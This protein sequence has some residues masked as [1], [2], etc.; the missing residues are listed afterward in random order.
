[1]INGLTSAYENKIAEVTKLM[2][3]FEEDDALVWWLDSKVP[4]EKKAGWIEFWA[5]PVK[6]VNWSRVLDKDKVKHDIE[7][8]FEFYKDIEDLAQEISEVATEKGIGAAESEINYLSEK[9]K[10]AVRDSEEEKDMTN[11]SA[12]YHLHRRLISVQSRMISKLESV[13][14]KASREKNRELEGK[15]ADSV[16]LNAECRRLYDG[17]ERHNR[18]LAEDNHE[19]AK[20][21][22]TVEEQVATLM[23]NMTI[24]SVKEQDNA[25]GN[26]QISH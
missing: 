2:N 24:K 5:M 15:L 9:L 13:H 25:R 1:M 26:N 14:L 21:L 22:T 18:K 23:Q 12:V 11:S 3:K 17:S 20:R 19:L 7:R 10:A 8:F 4:E 6:N 16:N